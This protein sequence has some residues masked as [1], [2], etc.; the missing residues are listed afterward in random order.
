MPHTASNPPY[1]PN[2][3]RPMSLEGFHHPIPRPALGRPPTTAKPPFTNT[4]KS[5]Q[6]GPKYSPNPARAKRHKL[7]ELLQ[8]PLLIFGSIIAGL[9]VQ[10]LWFGVGLV[11]LYG[12][13]AL[14]FRIKSS[15]TFILAIISFLAVVAIM[16][17]QPTS[18][19]ANNFA[20]YAFL[21]L[22]IGVIA[23]AVEVRPQR[24]R[25]RQRG[26]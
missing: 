11:V 9:M 3:S 19:L 10:A 6:P 20:N 5:F 14:I 1:L 7:W 22:T 24:R 16:A 13:C 18:S 4:K 23:L 2:R 21:L 15:T 12:L 25:K 26:R 8:L 17:A